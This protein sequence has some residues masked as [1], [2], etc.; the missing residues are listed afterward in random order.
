MPSSSRGPC[1]KGPPEWHL[2][3][4]IHEPD[5]AAEGC[6]FGEILPTKPPKPQRAMDRH[7]RR[8]QQQQ[9]QQQQ[10]SGSTPTGPRKAERGTT[11][12]RKRKV[13]DK[14]VDVVS[15]ALPHAVD[16]PW[17]IKDPNSLVGR[18][19][20]ILWNRT[21]GVFYLGNIAAYN[22]DT[23][24]HFVKFDDGDSRWYNMLLKTFELVDVQHGQARQAY[25][26][27]KAAGG[28]G[29]AT[30]GPTFAT[31][32]ET[33]ARQ[34][35]PADPAPRVRSA[36]KHST[37]GVREVVPAAS[38]VGSSPSTERLLTEI[39]SLRAENTQLRSEQA[40]IQ[41]EVAQGLQAV[42]NFLPDAIQTSQ[43]IYQLLDTYRSLFN[44]FQRTEQ[45]R[46]LF[47]ERFPVIAPAQ[48]K[49]LKTL[50]QMLNSIKRKMPDGRKHKGDRVLFETL[51]NFSE[52]L[53]R[54]GVEEEPVPPRATEASS[55]ADGAVAGT[56]HRRNSVSPTT[57]GQ[58]HVAS[59]TRNE[60]PAAKRPRLVEP[61]LG[62]QDMR[63]G[64]TETRGPLHVSVSS[65][66]S[67]ML[68]VSAVGA[69]ATAATAAGGGAMAGHDH[70][71]PSPRYA[72]VNGKLQFTL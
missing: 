64:S 47:I 45:L 72:E 29:Q 43:V 20:R 8:W 30:T 19:A 33:V 2:P 17:W 28:S 36:V 10:Q 7:A 65:S 38:P 13:D 71:G 60:A 42:E 62:V 54:R 40:R 48:M 16:T 27:R 31:E 41:R 1:C 69:R 21:R 5:P 49:L 12:S 37:I 66:T 58:K 70:P 25:R 57:V 15:K 26:P 44:M 50:T 34:A 22:Q 39:L 4:T 9:Q 35:E 32:I 3:S 11:P 63:K 59:S 6:S 46:S 61:S 23:C 67:T 56:S 52:Q 51:K 68:P 53:G 18:R 14:K 24:N 55:S